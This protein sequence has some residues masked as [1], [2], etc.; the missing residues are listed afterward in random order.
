M[1]MIDNDFHLFILFD[2]YLHHI[3]TVKSLQK[4]HDMMQKGKSRSTGTLNDSLTRDTSD[5]MGKYNIK[6]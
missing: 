2:I 3:C 4:Y 5:T 6:A 1:K